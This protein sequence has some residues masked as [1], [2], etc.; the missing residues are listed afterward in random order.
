MV[1][2]NEFVAQDFKGLNKKELKGVII[3]KN[4][5]IE[6]LKLESNNLIIERNELL[7]TNETLTEQ[8]KIVHALNNSLSIELNKEKDKVRQFKEQ[9]SNVN[10]RLERTLDSIKIKNILESKIVSLNFD[11]DMTKNIFN[12]GTNVD[13]LEFYK[14]IFKIICLKEMCQNRGIDNIGISKLEKYYEIIIGKVENSNFINSQEFIQADSVVEFFLKNND[15]NEILKN[16]AFFSTLATGLPVTNIPCS[17]EGDLILCYYN[18]LN[19]GWLGPLF[20]FNKLDDGSKILS[21][22][23][24]LEDLNKNDKKFKKLTGLNYRIKEE[25][26]HIKHDFGDVYYFTIPLEKDKDPNC[27]PSFYL[28]VKA[29]YSNHKFEIIDNIYWTNDFQSNNWRILN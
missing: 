11:Y 4:K 20:I 13:R 6:S 5:E 3:Q 1:T 2:I 7:N 29:K 10:K 27:C 12:N 28:K 25:S 17:I 19:C 16:R 26:L 15:E 23:H 22:S 8:L 18:Q 24:E 14:R 9:N 21:V